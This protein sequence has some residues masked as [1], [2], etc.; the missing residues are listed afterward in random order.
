[1]LV[2]SRKCVP[3]TPVCGKLSEMTVALVSSTGVYLEGQPP[4]GDDTDS[5]YRVLPGDLN[6]ADLR[7][8]HGHYDESQAQQDAN[9]VFPMELLQE[10]AREGVIRR[11]GNKNIGFR[12]FSTNLKFMYEEVAPA[13]A[14]EIERS[15]AEGVVLTG[16]CPV[17]HRVVVAVQR[18]I[19]AKGIPTVLITAVPAESKIMRPPRSIHPVGSKPGH[20]LGSAGERER[21]RAVLL[22]ALRQFEMQRV[23]G[24]MVEISF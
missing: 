19:E 12:G 2:M 8:K 14:A 3:Y 24:E 13:I 17:C 23:P 16:G 15:Q 11:V 20:V 4:F 6:P 5:T 22:E 7:F 9:T 1:M 21:Q 10:M 18:E